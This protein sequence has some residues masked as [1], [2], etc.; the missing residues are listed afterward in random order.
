[1]RPCLVTCGATRNPVDAMRFLSAR[2]SGRSGIWLA[3]RLPGAHLLAG[4]EA[5]LLARP[6]EGVEEF[7]ST[8]DLL[9]RMERWIGANPTAVIVHA[10]AVGDYAVDDP[11]GKIASGQ[12]ELVLRLRPTPKI[13]DRIHGWAPGARLVSFKA[14]PP[15]TSS[16]ELVR[17]A[18]AQRVRT[19]S[20]VV[21]ANVLEALD[22]VAIVDAGGAE[23]FRERAPALES[24]LARIRTLREAA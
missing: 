8:Q 3:D 12:P 10:A 11:S 18:E 5:R 7:G 16:E 15:A 21:F 19:H 6:R 4:A 22:T 2:S 14:A 17:L 20:A 24:L 13:I 1:M 9:E 23:H